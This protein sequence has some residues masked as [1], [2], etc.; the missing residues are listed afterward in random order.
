MYY[1]SLNLEIFSKFRSRN[2]NIKY[3]MLPFITLLLVMLLLSS[4]FVSMFTRVSPFASGA[5]VISVNNESDLRAA[6]STATEPIIIT[7]TDNIQLTG[8]PLE[9]PTGS[10][11][12]LKNADDTGPWKLLG[13]ANYAT[14]T[15]NGELVLDGLN[16]THT[17]NGRGITVNSAGTLTM[18]SGVI[19]GNTIYGNGGGVYNAGTFEMQ[20]GVIANNTANTNNL[21][22]GGGGVYNVGTF[23]VSGDGC[24]IANNTAAGFSNGGGVHN[25]GSF[26][27]SGTDC[28]IANNTATNSGGGVH[29]L[30]SSFVVSGDGCM[31]ANNTAI[32]GGG[33]CNDYIRIAPFTGS[34]FTMSN[35][36][37]IVNNT[38]TAG[39]GV[40]N[41][42]EC[43]FNMF[44]GVIA[45]NTATGDGGGVN[46]WGNFTMHYGAIVSNKAL[47]GGGVYS[48]AYNVPEFGFFNM[49]GGVIANNT[50]TGSNGG[51]GV[52]ITYEIG[53]PPIL[54]GGGYMFGGVIANNTASSGGGV[55]IRGNFTMS[56]GVISDN[57]ATWGGGVYNNAGNF[58][59]SGDGKLFNNTANNY[60]GGI[61]NA[62]A[63]ALF[64]MSHG[65]IANNTAYSGG[66]VYIANGR[67]N[68]SGGV[69]ANNTARNNGGGIWATDTNTNLNRLYVAEDV[70]FYGNHAATAYAIYDAADEGIYNTQIEGTSWTVPFTWGYNNYDI[71]YVRGTPLTLYTVTFDANADGDSAVVPNPVSKLVISGDEYGLLALVSRSG[72]NFEGW[73]TES[74]GGTI[75][76]EASIVQAIGDHTLFAQWTSVFVPP[77]V[78]VDDFM[79]FYNGNGASGGSVPVDNNVYGGGVSVVVAANSGGLV[80]SG[81]IFL[82]WAYSSTAK[83]ADFVVTG[84]SVS[85]SIFII[86]DDVTLFAVWSAVSY[87]V[88]YEP[89][90]HGT[91]NVVS[92]S[93]L[94]YGDATPAAPNVTGQT[95]WTFTGWTPTPTLTVTSNATYVAQWTQTTTPPPTSS[96]TPTTS[97]TSSPT[98]TTSPTITPPIST[99]TPT[100]PSGG[101]KEPVWAL[102]NLAISVTGFILAIIVLICILLQQQQQKQ[103]T[104]QNTINQDGYKSNERQINQHRNIWIIIMFAMGVAGLIVFLLT[105]DTSFSMGIVDKWTIVSAIPFAVELIAITFIFKHQKSTLQKKPI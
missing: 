105:E 64:E 49:L 27:V 84:S 66:G 61:Y 83:V 58:S 93:G 55:M 51:G 60:G 32:E 70:E 19:F 21:N 26:V 20:G 13:A 9:I 46:N 53:S 69:I 95:G 52:R 18:L 31:I 8:S 63:A 103:K 25:T 40:R 14:I 76:T 41:L 59:L 6:I 11:I 94:F 89:G 37:M 85:P 90:T 80:R 77:P 100:P 33:V 82:G 98:P 67:V 101:D 22:D 12:T 24:L 5:T 96:P 10:H 87:T 15:V 65:N 28:L 86:Y 16:V 91:F 54:S 47:S 50:A 3:F 102:A 92:F 97:P 2:F 48:V 72:Y 81:Y 57:I 38:A 79:V 36:C 44:G 43:T 34:T 7:L 1:T 35:D 88:S 30:A 78:V 74:V 99:P 42:A 4:P 56:G 45:N 68:V 62:G 17:G 23:T 75:I 73:F 29:N 104:N 71:S 39:G